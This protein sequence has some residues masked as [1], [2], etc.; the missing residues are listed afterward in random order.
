MKISNIMLKKKQIF[1]EYKKAIDRNDNVST[2][3]I[4]Y[5]DNYN[6]K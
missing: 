6:T 1:K 4:E 3:L 2:L 5:A